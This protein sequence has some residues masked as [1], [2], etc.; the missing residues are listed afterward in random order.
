MNTSNLL[1]LSKLDNSKNQSKRAAAQQESYE[2][3]QF[4][5]EQEE[6]KQDD[7]SDK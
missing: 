6:M 7:V 5:D 4:L 2:K 3:I 1:H